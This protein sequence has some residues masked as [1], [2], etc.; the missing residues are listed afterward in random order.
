SFQ[1]PKE[2][3]ATG[4]G[5]GTLMPIIPT[6]ISRWNL[7]AAPPSLVNTAVPLPYGPLLMS[8]MP[9]SK[10]FTRTTDSSGPKISSTYTLDEVGTPSNSVGPSQNPSD[11]PLG[12]A[13]RPS[14][15]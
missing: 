10:V 14:T 6:W 7:R 12:L 11:S 5:I 1:P 15:T 3:Y 13:S 4:T 2:W 9:S 8:S